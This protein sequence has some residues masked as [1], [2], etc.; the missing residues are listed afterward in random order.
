MGR[1]VLQ[2]SKSLFM[3][4]KYIWEVIIISLQLLRIFNGK[5]SL[6]NSIELF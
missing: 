3:F 4:F 1:V 5:I 6:Y 2:F